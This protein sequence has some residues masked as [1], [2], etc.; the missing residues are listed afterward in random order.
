MKFFIDQFAYLKPIIINSLIKI[1]DI[2]R[3]IQYRFFLLHLSFLDI[4]I[5]TER[6]Q[7]QMGGHLRPQFLFEVPSILLNDGTL[8]MQHGIHILFSL[9]QELQIFY[10]LLKR[11]QILIRKIGHIRINPQQRPLILLMSV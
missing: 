2:R 7:K 1:L 10:R 6:L 5:K 4:I 8:F 11:L 9:E 3:C